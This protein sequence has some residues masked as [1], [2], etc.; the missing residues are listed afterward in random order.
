[1][2]EASRSPDVPVDLLACHHWQPTEATT[3]ATTTAWCRKGCG[4]HI[5]VIGQW[6]PPS[7][8]DGADHG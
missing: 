7:S 1:M 4:F 3:T 5:E 2:N 6:F 8:S